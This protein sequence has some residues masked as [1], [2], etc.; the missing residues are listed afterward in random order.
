VAF[1]GLIGGHAH[2]G[3]SYSSSSPFVLVKPRNKGAVGQKKTADGSTL[4]F[5]KTSAAGGKRN[6]IH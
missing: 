3:Y 6:G 4:L 1:S 2:C 5:E